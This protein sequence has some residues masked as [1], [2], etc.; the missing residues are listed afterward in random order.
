MNSLRNLMSNNSTGMVTILIQISDNF[1]RMPQIPKLGYEIN[2]VLQ[3]NW[4]R[5]DRMQSEITNWRQSTLSLSTVISWSWCLCLLLGWIELEAFI[6]DLCFTCLL[7]SFEVT[8]LCCNPLSCSDHIWWSCSEEIVVLLIFW[9]DIGASLS[10]LS[11]R[12]T[13]LIPSPN[14]E[15]VTFWWN[16]NLLGWESSLFLWNCYSSS[17]RGRFWWILKLFA[18]SWQNEV[19][20]HEYHWFLMHMESLIFH[21]KLK[22][23]TEN[24]SWSISYSVQPWLVGRRCHVWPCLLKFQLHWRM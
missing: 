20:V 13:Q 11:I 5:R 24:W 10:L 18:S 3:L 9:G 6:L 1:I 2:Y 16:H 4:S 21:T 15:S 19:L 7:Q 17:F 12:K 14:L 23:V 8:D 22:L